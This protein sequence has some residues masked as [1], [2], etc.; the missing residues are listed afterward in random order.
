MGSDNRKRLSKLKSDCM[1]FASKFNK[2]CESFFNEISVGTSNLTEYFETIHDMKLKSC[3]EFF[4]DAKISKNA[5][6]YYFEFT[7][8]NRNL[9]LI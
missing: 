3:N 5:C 8:F 6:N 1:S 2:K 4:E 7:I 9:K